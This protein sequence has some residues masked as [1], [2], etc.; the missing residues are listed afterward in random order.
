M[1]YDDVLDVFKILGS[2]VD[3]ASRAFVSSFQKI[4]ET[5]AGRL[6][7]ALSSGNEGQFRKFFSDLKKFR[8]GDI[9]TLPLEDRDAAQAIK[10]LSDD[11]WKALADNTQ[12]AELLKVTRERGFQTEFFETIHSGQTPDLSTMRTIHAVDNEEFIN[13]LNK[14][15]TARDS[16]ADT[17]ALQK[18]ISVDEAR[19]EAGRMMAEQ[20]QKASTPNLT[21]ASSSTAKPA[22]DV[23]KAAQAPQQ[24]VGA[25]E[26]FATAAG[27]GGSPAPRRMQTPQQQQQANAGAGNNA[28]AGAKKTPS[29][30]DTGLPAFVKKSFA[31]NDPR[32]DMPAV[33]LDADYLTNGKRA[34]Q[35]WLVRQV[36]WAIGDGKPFGDY[37]AEIAEKNLAHA[38]ANIENAKKNG[39]DPSN[40][41]EM[42]VPENKPHFIHKAVQFGP[43]NL[44]AYWRRFANKF[45]GSAQDTFLR[46]LN[47]PNIFA[48]TQYL[49]PL[50]KTA[51]ERMKV[52]GFSGK[53]YDMQLQMRD[54][55]EKMATGNMISASQYKEEMTKIYQIITRDPQFKDSA[56]ELIESL[57]GVIKG[58]QAKL[59]LATGGKVVLGPD[60]KQLDVAKHAA[61][62]N[63]ASA[64]GKSGLTVDQTQEALDYYK[65][66]K[67]TVQEMIAPNNAF[68]DKY[69]KVVPDQLTSMSDRKKLAASMRTTFVGYH[70]EDGVVG[71]SRLGRIGSEV[72]QR[73]TG[74]NVFKY[75]SKSINELDAWQKL[76]LDKQMKIA[77]G[78]MS[79]E[80][81]AALSVEEKN[82]ALEAAKP[83]LKAVEARYD[84]L[85][86]L[87]RAI[88]NGTASIHD[89]KAALQ[90]KGDTNNPEAIFFTLLD[91]HRGVKGEWTVPSGNMFATRLLSM[92]KQGYEE[93]IA[94]L[95]DMLIN[96]VG[97]ETGKVQTMPI[98]QIDLFINTAIKDA[99]DDKYKT[100]ILESI[101]EKLSLLKQSPMRDGPRDVA[102]NTWMPY[103]SAYVTARAFAATKLQEIPFPGKG[104]VIAIGSIFTDRDNVE[105]L[106]KIN[107]P[108]SAPQSYLTQ[109]WSRNNIIA[110]PLAY[111][112]GTE[113]KVPSMMV[114][115]ESTIGH[116]PHETI[117]WMRM[118]TLGKDVFTPKE[119]KGWTDT[120][121]N[122]VGRFSTSLGNAPGI[123]TVFFRPFM[124]GIDL[125][126][127][128]GVEK[129][130]ALAYLT[131]AAYGGIFVGSVAY[132]GLL[133]TS[134]NYDWGDAVRDTTNNMAFI[135]QT[136]IKIGTAYA[137]PRILS[138]T[139]K[140]AELAIEGATSFAGHVTGNGDSWTIRNAN[141]GVGNF[142]LDY[143]LPWVDKSLSGII[144]DELAPRIKIPDLGS[145][146]TEVPVF[147]PQD[148]SST[149][150][151]TPASITQSYNSQQGSTPGWTAPQFNNR[152]NNLATS[153]AGL[154]LGSATP[155]STP[156]AATRRPS[157]Q[158]F[159]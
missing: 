79:D 126:G 57:D 113:T 69:L 34:K 90:T 27:G 150:W 32:Y 118:V 52:T 30:E 139:E 14:F 59:D 76:S 134:S 135:P 37:N 96:D 6:N 78:K 70:L 75:S 115:E 15:T 19:K 84:E 18:G 110:R 92:E 47:M 114:R 23:A 87:E 44:G 138:A 153:G 7:T 151:G 116:Y 144:A 28:S 131:R 159:N 41:S 142:I 4:P 35:S 104:P 33:D 109:Q 17:I 132:T 16:L 94:E 149:G 146:D 91:E 77:Q 145:D 127:R 25:S 141:M 46:H 140:V 143:K 31:A 123:A 122:A 89:R 81:W 83:Q 58:L 21:V 158:Q 74:Y 107:M 8:D 100:D 9:N 29:F 12:A 124:G 61:F 111:L 38:K 128:G 156:S 86:R 99:G 148:R 85:T 54:I 102:A 39:V 60:G 64:G 55:T 45:G 157:W 101:R 10:K 88:K 112:L 105:K 152:A 95:V 71:G 1:I 66:I 67:T 137:A 97:T 5:F 130:G 82:A 49:R 20:Q 147:S 11:D 63:E 53:I 48:D 50:I 125:L 2:N 121:S 155:D 73:A 51:D 103:Y 13:T 3:G 98:G 117:N 72:E 136:S 62:Q 119:V 24:Q 133:S 22:E 65:D 93:M 80:K 43:E 68:L 154:Q 120:V 26:V 36:S 106:F 56:K 42:A 108:A 129:A 40:I